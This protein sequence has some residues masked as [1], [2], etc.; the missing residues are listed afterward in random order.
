RLTGAGI[1]TT[2]GLDKTELLRQVQ[3]Q[4]RTD[5]LTGLTNL[6]QPGPEVIGPPAPG[7][8]TGQPLRGSETLLARVNTDVA[9]T[10]LVADQS[11]KL[12]LREREL[13]EDIKA[14]EIRYLKQ[15]DIREHQTNEYLFLAAFEV[16]VYEDRETVF[17]RKA[18]LQRRLATFGPITRDD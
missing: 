15:T 18:Q 8:A 5:P 1:Q 14:T 4:A 12:R 6:A 3:L 10:I 17:K 9:A 13:A 11:K 2:T 7:E 16:N